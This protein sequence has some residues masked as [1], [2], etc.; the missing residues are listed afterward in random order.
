MGYGHLR[1]MLDSSQRAS[2]SIQL[3]QRELGAGTNTGGGSAGRRVVGIGVPLTVGGPEESSR[4]HVISAHDVAQQHAAEQSDRLGG[5]HLDG[6][7]LEG[8]LD[9]TR[10]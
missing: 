3:T 2:D 8:V 9:L 10:V 1:A 5:N 7:N 4:P 6:M